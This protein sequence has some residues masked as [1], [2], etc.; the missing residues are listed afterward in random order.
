[1]PETTVATANQGR[2]KM[3]EVVKSAVRVLEI[4]EFFDRWQAPAPVGAIAA[5]LGYP[6]SSTSALMRSLVK[7]GY[8]SYD[9]VHRTFS[10]T[11]RIPLLGSWVSSPFLR[12]GPVLEVAHAVAERTGIS[13]GIGRRNGTQVQWLHAVEA[14]DG[15]PNRD[16]F[17]FKASLT[18]S[19]IGQILLADLIDPGMQGL[20]HRLNSESSDPA[21]VVRFSDM[22]ARIATIRRDGYS[23]VVDGDRATLAMNVRGVSGASDVAITLV[24]V[25]GRLEE[26]H[27]RFVDIMRDCMSAMRRDAVGDAIALKRPTNHGAMNVPRDRMISIPRVAAHG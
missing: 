14:R 17:D 24:D 10:P 4:L 19:A 25:T 12:K 26:G 15:I 13:V 3:P 9:A 18:H 23:Y 7:V 20:L 1:M 16:V 2:Q 6:Q 22:K 5:D 27:A 11:H 21:R 8:L